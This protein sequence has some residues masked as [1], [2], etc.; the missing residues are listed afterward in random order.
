MQLDWALGN[1]ELEYRNW[2][3][4]RLCFKHFWYSRWFSWG[5]YCRV[6]VMP[7]A[8]IG[9]VV[10]Y[11]F[12]LKVRSSIFKVW[13]SYL[14]LRT[15]C[16]VICYQIVFMKAEDVFKPSWPCCHKFSS[17]CWS[18]KFLPRVDLCCQLYK[19]AFPFP[20]VAIAFPSKTAFVRLFFLLFFLFVC[21]GCLQISLIEL[22]NTY[23]FFFFQVSLASILAKEFCS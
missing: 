11:S 22:G 12:I 16:C 8:Y 1:I 5:P 15:K 7:F 23:R 4:I 3:S 9:Y 6:L 20:V 2:I 13:C 21:H 18:I 17:S 19:D 10:P 14:P